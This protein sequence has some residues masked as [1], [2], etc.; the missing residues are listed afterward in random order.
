MSEGT[1]APPVP[2]WLVL[3]QGIAAV[4]VALVQLTQPGVDNLL[5]ML[6]L[7]GVYWLLGGVLELVDLLIDGRRWPWR[8][9]GAAA[10]VAA[11]IAVLREP[12]WSTQLVPHLVARTMGWFGLAAGIVYLV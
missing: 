4:L 5:T 10:G 2:T 12:L 6:T 9:I 7:L 8:L 11:G 3:A 1:L